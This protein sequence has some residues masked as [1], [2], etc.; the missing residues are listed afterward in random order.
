MSISFISTFTKYF[1]SLFAFKVTFSRK[2]FQ[3]LGL[4]KQSYWL[5]IIEAQLFSKSY[6]WRWLFH[7]R[8]LGTTKKNFSTAPH[9]QFGISGHAILEEVI[10]DRS[11]QAPK[12]YMVISRTYDQHALTKV[13]HEP[14][15]TIS[16]NFDVKNSIK[17]S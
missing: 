14:K 8:G 15:F 1:F 5:H 12:M 6:Q 9:H 10:W 13:I 3:T 16:S 17:S 4:L 11:S 2:K 7:Q